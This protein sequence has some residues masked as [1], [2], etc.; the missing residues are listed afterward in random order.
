MSDDEVREDIDE[1]VIC[2]NSPVDEGT[3]ARPATPSEMSNIF[4]RS[5]EAIDISDDVSNP[6][7]RIKIVDILNDEAEITGNGKCIDLVI[8]YM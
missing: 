3:L 8:L 4:K 5:Y 6:I 7:K 1:R 2:E